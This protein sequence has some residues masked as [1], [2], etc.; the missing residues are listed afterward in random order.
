[1][2]IC[3]YQ[4][5]VVDLV[6][7]QDIIHVFGIPLWQ[8]FHIFFSNAIIGEMLLGIRNSKTNEP[9]NAETTA[10]PTANQ[11]MDTMYEQTRQ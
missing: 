1:M 7:N 6:E 8:F 11:S 4:L 10:T 9:N 5:Q 3:S 2:S